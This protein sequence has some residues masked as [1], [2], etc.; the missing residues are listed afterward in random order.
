MSNINKI[1]NKIF[2]SSTFPVTLILPTI[3]LIV[4]ITHNLCTFGLTGFIENLKA[5]KF[6]WYEPAFSH[7]IYILVINGFSFV[8]SPN[9]ASTKPTNQ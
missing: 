8:N 7:L 6:M 4:I 1:S 5:A 3:G 9:T 2:H